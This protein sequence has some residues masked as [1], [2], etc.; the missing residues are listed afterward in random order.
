MALLSDS[1]RSGHHSAHLA[2]LAAGLALLSACAT[3]PPLYVINETGREIDV[4]FATKA[5][6]HLSDTR[7]TQTVRGF[8]E[9]DWT[10]KAANCLYR[11][12][13]IN[14]SDPY[15]LD[16]A[17]TARVKGT[18]DLLMRIGEDFRVRA[19]SYNARSSAMVSEELRI[20]GL[21][22]TPMKTCAGDA[23]Q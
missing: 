11:Y 20:G 10:L 8:P 9:Y 18:P 13:A 23:G 1:L 22:M 4:V 6:F 17:N 3:A 2:V 15:W 7:S 12:P 19:Y 21:P 14:T 5:R 16:Y